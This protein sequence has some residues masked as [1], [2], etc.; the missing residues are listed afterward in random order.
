M[1]Y[2]DQEKTAIQ[3]RKKPLSSHN[4]DRVNQSR[5]Y[6]QNMEFASVPS[7]AG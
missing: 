5:S 4:T 6:V 1:I 2:T 3:I 7:I